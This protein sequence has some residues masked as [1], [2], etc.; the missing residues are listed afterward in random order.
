LV[1]SATLSKIEENDPERARLAKRIL[2]EYPKSV[3]ALRLIGRERQKD[4]IGVPFE[5]E[6]TDAISGKNIFDEKHAREGR[7][8]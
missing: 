8:P 2:D 3:Q 6:F 5:L 7:R 4:Q 1:L